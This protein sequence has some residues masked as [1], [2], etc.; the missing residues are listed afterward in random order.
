M[1]RRRRRKRRRIKHKKH[2]TRTKA[3][4]IMRHGRVRGKRLTKKQRGY[5]GLL[6]G[7]G[8]PTRLKRRKRKRKRRRRR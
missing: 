3:K 8:K 4:K 5:F 6:A 1:V 7:G 2:P